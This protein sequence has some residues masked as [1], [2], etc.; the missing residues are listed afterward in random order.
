MEQVNDGQVRFGWMEKGKIVRITT[1]DLEKIINVLHN[2]P[3]YE[4]ALRAARS[5]LTLRRLEKITRS[6]K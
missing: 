3:G 6:R 2:E 5:E 4:A 1:K